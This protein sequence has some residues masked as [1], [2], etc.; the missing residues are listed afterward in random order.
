MLKKNPALTLRTPQNL[1]INQVAVFQNKITE[2]FEEVFK[3]LGENHLEEDILFD[4]RKLLNRDMTAFFNPTGNKVL[5][6]KGDK[7]PF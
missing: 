7:R 6:K 4:P 3:Y 1:T 5:A 2:W